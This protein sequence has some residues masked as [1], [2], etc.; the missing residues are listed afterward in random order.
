VPAFS[1]WTLVPCA[2]AAFA[3]SGCANISGGSNDAPEPA[4]ALPAPIASALKTDIGE[5]LVTPKPGTSSKDIQ[6]TID[7]LRSMPGVQSAELKEGNVDVQFFGG[8][9][10]EQ[11]EKAVKQLAALGEVF[12]G[13]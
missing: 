13:V 3:L 6:A 2:A 11:R 1:R 8:S 9:T 10:P 12:E 5:Y 4:K 7:Q